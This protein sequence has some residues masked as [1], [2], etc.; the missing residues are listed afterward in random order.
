MDKLTVTKVVKT[1]AIAVTKQTQVTGRMPPDAA[2]LVAEAEPA[3]APSAAATTTS[4]GGVTSTRR[5]SDRGKTS[6]EAEYLQ[7]TTSNRS[8]FIRLV[9]PPIMFAGTQQ[10]PCELSATLA[11]VRS[12]AVRPNRKRHI[13]G[14][15]RH[16]AVSGVERSLGF[17]DVLLGCLDKTLCS[18][19]VVRGTNYPT[20][21]GAH[22][23][24]EM[25]SCSRLHLI[26]AAFPET[27]KASA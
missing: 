22:Q 18:R 9:V 17:L 16:L 11:G 26:R 15:L 24:W 25:K 21:K 6:A 4:A 12:R 23:I 13:S 5:A 8:L 2:V 19:I 3:P 20:E 1:P 27:H 10:T 7:P 14:P